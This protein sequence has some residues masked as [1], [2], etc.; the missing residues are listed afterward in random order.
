MTQNLGNEKFIII[1]VYSYLKCWDLWI[2]I[3]DVLYS[4]N[5]HIHIKVSHLTL[6]YMIKFGLDLFCIILNQPART[7]PSVNS[8]NEIFLCKTQILGK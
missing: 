1:N 5:D 4:F 6:H 2:K 8:D 7:V 3:S